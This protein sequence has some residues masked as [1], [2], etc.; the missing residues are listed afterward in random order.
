MLSSLWTLT[1][2]GM[3]DL[4]VQSSDQHSIPV[5][6]IKFGPD[7]ISF[8]INQTTILYITFTDPTPISLTLSH[9][10]A[11]I[12]SLQWHP[13]T[14]QLL[15]VGSHFITVLDCP[16]KAELGF[17]E[18]PSLIGSV[19]NAFWTDDGFFYLTNRKVLGFVNSSFEEHHKQDLPLL[20]KPCSA[21]LEGKTLFIGQFR[22]VSI[23]DLEDN[24][25]VVRHSFLAH[26]RDVE[27]IDV[28][29]NFIATWAEDGTV[30][31]EREELVPLF[32][33]K[34]DGPLVIDPDGELAVGKEKDGTA[35]LIAMKKGKKTEV[36]E[37]LGMQVGQRVIAD[38]FRK[39]DGSKTVALV[40]EGGLVGSLV[41]IQFTK[42]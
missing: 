35:V 26:P 39:E 15:V 13:L 24:K 41:F 30:I 10:S 42:K 18:V 40:D 29:K 14:F 21:T 38:W 33:V 2:R 11:Q 37:S 25:A 5:S 9:E 23:V 17:F 27:L 16:H 22:N 12:H 36:R 19:V 32:K 28:R 7:C 31:W 20:S 3:H 1:K 6:S 8:A 34:A 4:D